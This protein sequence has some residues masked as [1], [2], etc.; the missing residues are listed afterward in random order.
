MKKITEQ[1]AAKYTLV[2]I[3]VTFFVRLLIAAYT[4]LGNGESYYFRG[5]IHLDWSY[6]DQPPLFF[7]IGGASIRL[8]GLTNFGL[9]F[10]DV[11]MFAGTSWLLFALS[12]KLFNAAAGFWA[13]TVMNLSALFT[14]GVACWYQPDAPLMF[15]WLLSTWYIVKVLGIGEEKP[16][17]P[18][19]DKGKVYWLWIVIGICMGLATLSKYHV[20]FL[21]AGVFMF[22][23]TNKKQRHWLTH[24]GP[25][26]AIVITIIMATPVIWWNYKNNWVSFVWQG[27]R[28]GT[29]DEA[30]KIHFDWFFRSIAGQAAW[31]LPWIWFPTIRQMFIAYKERVKAEYGF[32]FWMSVLPIVFFTV[33]TL[34]ADLQYHFHWQAPG[35]MMLFMPLGFAIDKALNSRDDERRRLTRRWLNFSICFTTIT[36]IVL[37][38]HLVTGFW[39]SYGPKWVASLGGGK[40]DPTIQ[41]VDYDDVMTRFEKEGWIKNPNVFAGSTRWWLAGKVD[42]ALRGKKDIVAFNRD[43][44]NLAFLVD[45]KTLVGKDCVI[46]G[47][48]HAYDETIKADGTPFFDS[49]TQLPDIPIIRGGVVEEHLQV[50]YCKNFH[51]S[52]KPLPDYPLYRQL[53]GLVPFG[54]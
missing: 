20:L 2:L 16:L 38:L 36:I 48:A 47:E 12:R 7:W 27:S 19:A 50:Y 28:A 39:Q 42:W 49:I 45:P 46:I 54:K 41:G 25:Y 33:L 44:R 31:L 3:I 52:A 11:L 6:F 26:L 24:P 30:F 8:F 4:G 40:I 21:F 29:R 15:F 32:N 51:Q 9:R 53:N 1:N 22:I 13:V 17:D 37:G 10:P 5:A 23:L 35:Y 43:P 14:V 18:K 34:W